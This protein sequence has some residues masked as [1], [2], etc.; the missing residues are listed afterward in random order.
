MLHKWKDSAWAEECDK[1]FEELNKYLAYSPILSKH[2]NEEILYAY[3]AVTTHSVCLVLVPIVEG[4]QKQ[5]YYVSKSFQEAELCHLPLEK[6][7]LAMV[8]ASKKLPHY[9]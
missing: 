2:E 3:I 1:A 4:V 6:A 7:I 9:F 5:V 8:H